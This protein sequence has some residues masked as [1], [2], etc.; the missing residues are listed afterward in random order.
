MN[1]A[2]QE[3]PEN[4]PSVE[5]A[6]KIKDNIWEDNL[7]EVMETIKSLIGN[8]GDRHKWAWIRNTRCKYVNVRIDMRNGGFVLEDRDGARISLDQLKYQYKPN[9]V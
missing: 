7:D 1:D 3:F 2:S 9:K 5:D 4:Q 6:Q 8:T